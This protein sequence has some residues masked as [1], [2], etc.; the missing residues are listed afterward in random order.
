MNDSGIAEDIYE[1]ADGDSDDNEDFIE[2]TEH[3]HA[4][5]YIH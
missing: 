3:F 4:I 1:L 2:S 5:R